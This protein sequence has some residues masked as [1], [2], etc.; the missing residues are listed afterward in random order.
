MKTNKRLG[1]SLKKFSTQKENKEEILSGELGIPQN[2]RKVV[3]VPNRDG[4]VY[5]RLLTNKNELIQALNTSM[6]AIYGLPVQIRRVKN[7][8]TI[9]G[10]TYT[11]YS[12][13]GSGVGGG[14]IPLPRH[15][16][17]HS[18]NPDMDM[19]SDPT[20]VYSRQMMHMLSYPSGTTSM[21]LGFNPG[22]YQYN[23]QWIYPQVTGVPSFA[24]YI[25]TVT[26]AARMALYYLDATDNGL[27][28]SAG[29][30]F[31]GG[32]TNPQLLAQYIPT[33]P[34]SSIPLMAV[35]LQTGTTSLDWS[36]LYDVRPW[37]QILPTGTSGGGGGSTPPTPVNIY[38][39]GQY[40]ATG[41]NI[42]FSG[43]VNVTASGSFVS[44][45]LPITTYFRVGQ[46]A[47][48]QGIS[49]TFWKVP[50][51][52]YATGSLGVFYNGHALI[53]GID[54]IEQIAQSG[55]FMYLSVPATG[56]YHLAHYGVPCYPQP[57]ISTGSPNVILDSFGVLMVDSSGSI[58]ADSNG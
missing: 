55:T 21:M 35:K 22:F 4:Y 28:I 42:D 10:K 27:K 23:N 19:G 51:N 34:Q 36:N 38:S 15:G 47:P 43:N 58:L 48:L 17:Q 31:S 7:T 30:L 11:R 44:V 57:F 54:Y 14:V 53:P 56:T 33:P 41:T 49:G 6:P 12:N 26:G 45:D 32:I 3:E 29:T 16:G 50:D 46:P 52:V 18:L 2:G 1:K 39:H 24:P 9:I 13:Q 5:A 40:V 25:P 8:Y 37:L 20:W